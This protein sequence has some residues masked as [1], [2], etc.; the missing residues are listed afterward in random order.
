AVDLAGRAAETRLT[1]GPGANRDAA[2]VAA[3][4][5]VQ[6]VRLEVD[7]HAAAHR[8]VVAAR[9]AEA[10]LSEA[11]GQTAATAVVLVGGGVDAAGTALGRGR[12][13]AAPH[14][15]AG[16]AHLAAGAD[17]RRRAAGI[18]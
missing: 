10:G 12:V 1:S 7:T 13:A 4:P 18:A 11:A 2:V 3:R 5:T 17:V 9:T 15:R 14:A 6:I 16:L 8:A